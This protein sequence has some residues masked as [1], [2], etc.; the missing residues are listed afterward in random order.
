M[1]QRGA[2]EQVY[3]IV[4]AIQYK[5]LKITH[6]L[7]KVGINCAFIKRCLEQ[8][9]EKGYVEK[10]DPYIKSHGSTIGK[11]NRQALYRITEKGKQFLKDV[12]YVFQV[13]S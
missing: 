13:C 5:P 4:K 12:D 10:V 3:A 2:I 1:K 6:I 8:L 7:R 9:M 11:S